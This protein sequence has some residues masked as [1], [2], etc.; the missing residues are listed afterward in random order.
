[1]FFRIIRFKDLAE[2]TLH[3]GWQQLV[4]LLD[5][6]MCLFCSAL[7]L[8]R[9]LKAFPACLICAGQ[10]SSRV[11]LP[12]LTFSCVVGTEEGEGCPD[13]PVCFSSQVSVFDESSL[14]GG[15]LRSSACSFY[16]VRH[17]LWF[18]NFFPCAACPWVAC[19]AQV[20]PLERTNRGSREEALSH[21]NFLL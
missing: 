6:C 16:A 9:Q 13:L 12:L 5:F 15:A 1:M 19:W 20:Q 14:L 4:S 7:C 21:L 18:P 2:S 17:F 11:S 10:F 8:W 3:A